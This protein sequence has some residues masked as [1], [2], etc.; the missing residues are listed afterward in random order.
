MAT[1]TGPSVGSLNLSLDFVRGLSCEFVEDPPKAFICSLCSL[2]LR[3]PH[4]TDCCGAYYCK[5]C[6]YPIKNN[7]EP[8]PK[9]EQVEFESMIDQNK[10]KEVNELLVY[11]ANREN[12][13]EWSGPV[14]ELEQHQTEVCD[15]VQVACPNGC[16]ERL[17]R[18]SLAEHEADFCPKRSTEDQ[19]K[20]LTRR[21]DTAVATNLTLED[22]TKS[23]KSKTKEL[24]AKNKE[25]K[26]QN[27]TQAKTIREQQIQIS[28]LEDMAKVKK[29]LRDTRLQ[30]DKKAEMKQTCPVCG[31]T[32]P[33]IR[34]RDFEKHVNSHFL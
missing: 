15:C 21:L 28:K 25:L 10:L 26:A 18:K 8:C 22:A 19:V 9:C 16:G 17:P 14:K 32:F 23:L 3:E 4:L 33:A 34:I 1:A 24:S 5:S 12:G 30:M 2:P 27:T 31:H 7:K 20:S 6:I 13:C 29:E 11:C